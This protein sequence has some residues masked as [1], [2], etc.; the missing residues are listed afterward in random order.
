M[1]R[2]EVRTAMSPAFAIR[3]LDAFDTIPHVRM[4]DGVNLISS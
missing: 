3:V 2:E 1:T 4:H